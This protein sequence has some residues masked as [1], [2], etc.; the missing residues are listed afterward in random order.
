MPY[1]LRDLQ[2]VQTSGKAQEGNKDKVLQ[3]PVTSDF[4]Q[5]NSGSPCPGQSRVSGNILVKL[6]RN[7]STL[8]YTFL[9]LCILRKKY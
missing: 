1:E 2:S 5:Q 6:R 3:Y 8:T 4:E 7:L 9:W